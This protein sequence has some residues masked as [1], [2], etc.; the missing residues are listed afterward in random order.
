M[1]ILTFANHKGG[2]GKTTG[3]EIFA[4]VFSQTPYNFKILVIDVDPQN[5][6][7]NSYNQA[8]E[9]S[10]TIPGYDVITLN[11]LNYVEII[12]DIVNNKNSEFILNKKLVGRSGVDTKN[13]KCFVSKLSR[14]INLPGVRIKKQNQILYN[15]KGGVLSDNYD[16]ILVDMPS[17]MNEILADI[18]AL[19]DGVLVPFKP[20]PIDITSLNLFIQYLK[21]MTKKRRKVLNIDTHIGAY[22]NEYRNTK[23]YKTAKAL[24]DKLSKFNV[25]L[26]NSHLQVRNIYKQT[27]CFDKSLLENTENSINQKTEVRNFTKELESFTIDLFSKP[28]IFNINNNVNSL[29]SF[30]QA[31][32]SKNLNKVLHLLKK[33][34]QFSSIND[35]V[36]ILIE[37]Y[38]T[39][40][41]FYDG[42]IKNHL[43]QQT[44]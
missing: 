43:N 23:E 8:L 14:T 24:K 34:H 29:N 35:A 7:L 17:D 40:N 39:G 10:N 41:H 33:H 20:N 38:K 25:K 11:E 37:N 5:S 15:Y 19:S 12:T 44:I 32:V 30:T 4:N 31:R 22:I 21:D 27:N 13:R 28:S 26:F 1:R 9:W 16:I 2:S 6:M 18:I 36:K 42:L 3:V